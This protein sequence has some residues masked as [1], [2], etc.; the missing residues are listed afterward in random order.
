MQAQAGVEDLAKVWYAT[1]LRSLL[2]NCSSSKSEKAAREGPA[3]PGALPERLA[4]LEIQVPSDPVEPPPR[5]AQ[6]EAQHQLYTTA[7]LSCKRKAGQVGPVLL[8]GL[9]DLRP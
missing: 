5:V 3:E 8:R 9:G 2:A 6:K 1:R 4:L 7:W